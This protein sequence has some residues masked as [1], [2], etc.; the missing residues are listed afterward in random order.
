MRSDDE[1][2]KREVLD[3]LAKASPDDVPDSDLR[4]EFA[5]A[6]RDA[7]ED[8]NVAVNVRREAIDV[9]VHWTGEFSLPILL[10][11]LE[12]KERYIQLDALEHL[13]E[14][15]DE[16][17]IERVT[18][19][20]VEDATL[21]DKAADCLRDRSGCRRQGAGDVSARRSGDHP[22]DGRTAG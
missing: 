3:R 1:A 17:S 10:G 7:A 8:A 18:R 14:M 9:L 5:L 15:P 19:L 16:Q 6:I 11:L 2:K 22:R 21:R 12:V 4:K 20:F 13:T